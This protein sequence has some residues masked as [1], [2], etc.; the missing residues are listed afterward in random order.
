M[1]NADYDVYTSARVESGAYRRAAVPPPQFKNHPPSRKLV[2][3][4]QYVFPFLDWAPRCSFQFF[5][6]DLI[7]GITVAS[8]AIPQASATPSLPIL[9]PI[10]GLYSSFVPPLI[11][12]MMRSSRDLAVGLLPLHHFL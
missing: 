1:G 5:K 8:L 4:M 2:L 6:A 3:R 10:L 11:Y 9:P 7:A 12:A